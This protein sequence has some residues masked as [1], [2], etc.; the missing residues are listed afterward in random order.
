MLSRRNFGVRIGAAAAAARLFTEGAYAQRAAVKLTDL[1]PGMV[2]L[3]ANEN[4]AGPPAA[5]LEAIQQVIAETGRYHFQEFR[6]FHETLARS[7]GFGPGEVVSGAGSTEVLNVAVQAFTAPDRPLVAPTPTFEAPVEMARALGRPVVQVPLRADY[8]ADVGK[9]AA[10]AA[11]TRAGLVYLCNPNNP[12]SAIT[13]RADLRRLVEHL[14]PASVLVVDEAYFHFAETPEIES[15]MPYAR[16]GRNV[17]VTRTFSKIYGMAGLR[18]GFAAG[19]PALIGRMAAYR[20]NVISIVAARAVLASLADKSIVPQRRAALARTRRE[21]CDWLRERKLRFIE[22]HANF[23]MLDLGRDARP[24]I[25]EMPR[26]GVAVGRPF[27]PLDNLLR[28]T[29]GTDQEMARFREV[30]WKVYKG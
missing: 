7:E 29:I 20:N 5:A 18:A 21:L 2:W 8:T 4:P 10:E 6:A 24:V 13:T 17:V 27:P 3:N 30:F 11:R 25:S 16:Q 14:P 12:T 28:V 23:I 22:P 15:A 26:M 19:P 9:L 1:P